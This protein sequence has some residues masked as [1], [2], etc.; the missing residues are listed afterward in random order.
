MRLNYSF[1]GHSLKNPTFAPVRRATADYYDIVCKNITET[2]KAGYAKA[3]WENRLEKIKQI[4]AK[5]EESTGYSRDK[6]LEICAKRKPIKDN[7][8][9]EEATVLIFRR[10][11]PAAEG[12][13]K[14]EQ[15]EGE[16][17]GTPEER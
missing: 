13:E 1:H 14:K 9:G 15:Q 8:I 6:Q 5:L 10:G 4:Q 11:K 3:V 7:D 12:K 17:D 2:M 16:K